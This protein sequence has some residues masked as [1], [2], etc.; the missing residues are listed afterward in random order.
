M[1]LEGYFL[2][3]S[4]LCSFSWLNIF[5]AR[6]VF[7]VDTFCLFLQHVLKIIPVIGGVKMPCWCLL[8]ELALVAASGDLPWN[9]QHQWQW[10]WLLVPTPKAC[11]YHDSNGGGCL[12]LLLETVGAVAT[13]ISHSWSLQL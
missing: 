8:P 6:V 7:T 11:D 5:G 1:V 10:L 3:E 13:T 12:H 2:C 4:I 9:M